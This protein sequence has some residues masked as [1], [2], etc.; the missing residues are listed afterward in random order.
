MNGVTLHGQSG[1]AE[2]ASADAVIVGSGI[3]TREIANNS[4]IMS[5]LRF[6]IPNAS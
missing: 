4:T 2:T 5:A 6:W 3:K 1:L